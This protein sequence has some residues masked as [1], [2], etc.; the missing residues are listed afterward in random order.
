[1]RRVWIETLNVLFPPVCCGCGTGTPQPGFCGPCEAGIPTPQ[2][3][4]CVVCGIPFSTRGG[5]DHPCSRCLR[6]PPRF[7]RARACALYD[8]AASTDVLKPVLQR[9]KY[10]RD[11]SL[12]PVLGGIFR[13]R[14][15]LPPGAY[16]VVVPV[17]L[18]LARLRW[19]GFN[20]ALL[21]AQHLVPRQV[22]DRYSLIRLRPTRPQ[23]EL[24]ETERRRNVA[25]AFHVTRPERI[26]G[27]RILLVD[28]VYTTGATVDACSA[29]LRRAGAHH[30]DVL[31]LAR[32]VR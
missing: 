31:V 21:L 3:P 22:I 6:Q 9:Y 19:R 17:P 8:A 2:S 15:A 20:Q 28:D 23:V 7:G 27:R 11:V 14:T 32:A 25:G 10:N 5:S 16:D 26:R 18:H 24:D 29:A 30:V 4:L 13:R 1:M 12:A